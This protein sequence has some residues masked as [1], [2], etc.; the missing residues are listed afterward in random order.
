MN[1]LLVWLL[2]TATAAGQATSGFHRVNQVIARSNSGTYAQV[3]PG[4]TI[5]VQLTSSGVAATIYS[6]PNLTLTIPGAKVTS[7]FSGN[8]SYYLPLNTCVT[9]NISSPSQGSLVVPNICGNA[10]LSLPISALNGGT[11]TTTAPTSGQILVGV[12]A[13]NAYSPVA[14]SGDC[15][16]TYTGAITCTKTNG[17]SFTSAA[18]TA[19]GTSGAVIPLLSTANT[20]SQNQT[21]SGT[22]T[23]GTT[24]G[25]YNTTGKNWQWVAQG[26]ASSDPSHFD[27]I[28]TTDSTTVLSFTNTTG[29]LFGSQI[30]TASNGACAVGSGTVTSVSF[31]TTPSWLTGSVATGTST[32]VLSLAASA[33]PN[34]ALANSV[35]T[36]NSVPCTLGSS[37][38]ISGTARTCNANGCYRITADGTIYQ[39][40]NQ[41]VT[42]GTF[43]FPY[44]FTTTANVAF[45]SGNSSSEGTDVDNCYGYATSTFQY[46]LATK[47]STGSITNYPCAWTAT[48]N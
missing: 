37:C 3:V 9:E 45:V 26:S 35:I 31:G 19:I 43:S 34:S 11:G 36:V 13:N 28:D 40:G 44:P 48:G 42:N 6:D 46:F 27:L 8:Y 4:A 17:A 33:I 10:G 39:W 15:S 22:G 23:T 5:F 47:A 14:L 21:F 12:M 32:P 20:W 25:I 29:T 24:L 16:L 1:R 7:D 18:T 30:C 2:L 41:A 38:N